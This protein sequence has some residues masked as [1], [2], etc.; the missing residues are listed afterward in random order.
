[1]SPYEMAE[2]YTKPVND[3]AVHPTPSNFIGA[4]TQTQ[5]WAKR[6]L[7]LILKSN[8]A[9]KINGAAG[10]RI[11]IFTKVGIN[12]RGKF[13]V[14]I[15]ALSIVKEDRTVTVPAKKGK[16]LVAGFEDVRVSIAEDCFAVAA[17][18]AI[19]CVDDSKYDLVSCN[20]FLVKPRCEHK[21]MKDNNV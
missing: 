21:N 3:S 8:S 18:E 17:Q 15:I 11:E 1:M 20:D 10:D 14:S 2:E 4:Q 5:L 12:K 9:D 16:R 7:T 6:K 19:D 13:L